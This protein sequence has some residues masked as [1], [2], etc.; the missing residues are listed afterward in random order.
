MTPTEINIA[1]AE[2]CGWK[3]YCQEAIDGN[4]GT[5]DKWITAPDGT[6]QLRHDIPNYHGNLNAMHEA[7]KHGLHNT[8]PSNRLFSYQDN[9]DMITRRTCTFPW[10][11]T[12]A[13]RAEAFLRTIGK[14]KE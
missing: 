8:P 6:S 3:M 14:W 5:K 2:A 7:E 9:L 4:W 10:F 1:I 12:A 11:A 13:Q